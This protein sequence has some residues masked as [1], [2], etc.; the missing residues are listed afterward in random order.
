MNR[1][2]RLSSPLTVALLDLDGF[3]QLN[4]A[5]GHQAGDAA[6]RAAAEPS[7]RRWYALLMKEE[8]EEAR[9]RA[10][11]AWRRVAEDGPVTL[12]RLDPAPR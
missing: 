3:K 12:W 2:S 10:P 4:D 8:L 9:A 6:L 5:A 7:G 1:A 11:A